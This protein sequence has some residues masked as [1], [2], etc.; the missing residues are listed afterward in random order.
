MENKL[1]SLIPSLSNPTNICF[2]SLSFGTHTA[3]DF[4][5]ARLNV[6][7]GEKHDIELFFA[8]SDTVAKGL[9]FL[10]GFVKSQ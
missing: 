9:Y 5:P 4:K 3:A 7:L 8:I 6:L 10:S 1:G 2:L